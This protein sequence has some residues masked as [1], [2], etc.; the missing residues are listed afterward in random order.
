M[1]LSYIKRAQDSPGNYRPVSLTSQV[2]KV[3]ESILKDSITD[4]LHK[5]KLLGSTQ[6]GF[7]K[8]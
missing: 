1:S 8:K 2:C 6:H 5:Y 3:M 4:H 7:V